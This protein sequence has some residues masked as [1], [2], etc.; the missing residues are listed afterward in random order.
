MECFL[1]LAGHEEYDQNSL[2]LGQHN[3]TN[4]VV[5]Q[6]WTLLDCMRFEFI[7]ECII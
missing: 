4:Y 2:N 7:I 3:L 6:A 1:V 5:S